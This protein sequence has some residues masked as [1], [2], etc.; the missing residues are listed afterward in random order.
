MKI[1]YNNAFSSTQQFGD[2]TLKLE[3]PII[4]ER[5]NNYGFSVTLYYS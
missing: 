2:M 4:L 3:S 5:D 1:N